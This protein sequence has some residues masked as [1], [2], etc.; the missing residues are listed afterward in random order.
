MA[1]EGV[2][3]FR[4]WLMARASPVLVPVG[5][6]GWEGREGEEE[7]NVKGGVPPG[8][9]E[10]K[11]MQ[12]GSEEG[13]VTMIIHQAVPTD[14]VQ[15]APDVKEAFGL[16]SSTRRNICCGKPRGCIRP[17]FFEHTMKPTSQCHRPSCIPRLS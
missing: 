11:E 12:K 5:G 9:E 14:F 4:P 3:K 1:G 7:T 6:G 10:T 17:Q 15:G 13:E 8:G 16:N 2:H